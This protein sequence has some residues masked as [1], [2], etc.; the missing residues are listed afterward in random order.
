MGKGHLTSKG[1][2]FGDGCEVVD[3]LFRA[4]LARKA[5]RCYKAETARAMK[6]ART[7][8]PAFTLIELLVVIAIIAILAAMLLPAL[9]R[10][11]QQAFR[12]QCT[13][14]QKQLAGTWMMYATD[15]NDALAS[16]GNSSTPT[17]A[18]KYWV[19]GYFYEP[20]QTTNTTYLLDARYALFAPYLRTT[21]VYVCP[22]DRRTVKVGGLDYPRL[23]SYAMNAYLGWVG[24]WDS[25]LSSSYR[26]FTKHS[27]M[28]GRMPTG[29]FLFSDVNPNSICWPYFGVQMASDTFFN[30]PGSAHSRGSVLSFSDGHAEFRRWTDAR[31]VTAYSPD[32]HKHADASPGN[33]DLAWL[34]QRTT[35][36]K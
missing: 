6:S 4:A 24:S 2:V 27:H 11:K 12:V 34:R 14:N 1:N 29:T 36:L 33:R 15:N 9:A 18:V 5:G 32:Y 3:K 17:T 23:R 8:P 30:F 7:E 31:T 28:T 22:S 16:N 21:R 10:A 35:V 25:R 13:N 20:A 26:V 19:Q